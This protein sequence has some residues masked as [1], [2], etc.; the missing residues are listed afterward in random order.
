M[1][2]C[3]QTQHHALAGLGVD[4]LVDQALDRRFGPVEQG[5]GL[6]REQRHSAVNERPRIGHDLCRGPV[7]D[8]GVHILDLQDFLH[9]SS[10]GLLIQNG[11]VE[12]PR[13]GRDQPA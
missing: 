10:E 3:G 7:G 8:L 6:C 13:G 11:L 12:P 4:G 9:G 2:L 1:D 5:V